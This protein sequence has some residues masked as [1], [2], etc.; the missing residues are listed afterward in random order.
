ELNVLHLLPEKPTRRLGHRDD[1]FQTIPNQ[2]EGNLLALAESDSDVG[3]T[4]KSKP[5][6][7]PSKV[8]D[9]SSPISPS[10]ELGR[11]DLRRFHQRIGVVLIGRAGP[12]VNNVIQGLFDYLQVW[13]G[14]VVCIAMGVA[15]L[16]HNYSFELTEEL[17]APHRNQGGCDLLGQSQPEDIPKLGNDMRSISHTVTRLKLDGLVVWG[18]AISSQPERQVYR[19]GA[20][21][22]DQWDVVRAVLKAYFPIPDMTFTAGTA[23]GR[24]FVFE[25]GQ[26]TMTTPLAMASSSKFPV[27]IAI[28]G[29]VKDGYLTFDTKAHEVWPW[30]S[31]DPSEPRSRVTLRHLLSFTSG[32]YWPDAS[33]YVPCLGAANASSY[34][35][36]E[37]AKEIYQQAPFEFEPG[38]TWSY[39]SF[40]LQVAG[41]MAATR[42]KLSTQQLLQKYLIHPL[43]L[44]NTSWMGGENPGLAGNMMTTPEDYDSILRAYVGNELL[45]PWVS[46]E[47]ERDYLAPDVQVSN[48]STFLVTLLGHYSFCN[49]FE[50]FPPKSAKFT[51]ECKKANIHMDAGLF[52][53]YP[54]VDRAKGMYMQIATAR[55][56]HSQKDFYAPTIASMVLRKMTKFLVDGALG[57]ESTE[58]AE[59]ADA[60]QVTSELLQQLELKEHWQSPEELW[61]VLAAP[62][63]VLV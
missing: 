35:A 3:G 50:C 56:P 25:K 55:V 11:F 42:A 26:T 62:E 59:A 24:Q 60:W 7:S 45:P 4:S 19:A 31:T 32:F 41:A 6:I 27:A 36:E 58:T 14:K 53:Y 20:A 39:N 40:H 33:G 29:A 61:A 28:A 10:S 18:G 63:E 47:M 34:S 52:G 46:F 38:S 44:K 17:L 5:P 15:G 1:S 23:K 37:C 8:M 21:G 13:E 54:L 43:N 51:P 30:W 22:F 16:I 57:V 49:Y 2:S 12:G 48:A 9:R